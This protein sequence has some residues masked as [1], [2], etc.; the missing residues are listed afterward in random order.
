MNFISNSGYELAV[1]GIV[2][3]KS[4]I[5]VKRVGIINDQMTD[6]FMNLKPKS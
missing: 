2:S 5:I 3:P 6:M 4:V 1:I